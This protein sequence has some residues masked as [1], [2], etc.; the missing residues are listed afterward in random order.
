M[1]TETRNVVRFVKIVQSEMLSFS[2]EPIRQKKSIIIINRSLFDDI[3]IPIWRRNVLEGELPSFA[4][5]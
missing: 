4:V 3:H 1:E 5:N 2:D